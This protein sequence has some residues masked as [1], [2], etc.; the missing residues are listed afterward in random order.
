M[1]VARIAGEIVSTPNWPDDVAFEG[2]RVGVIG[3]GSSGIQAIPV[4][5]ETAGHVTVFQRTPSFTVPARN[6]PLTSEAIASH[7]AR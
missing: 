7:K 1:T 4:I 6:A 3:T 5:A 2:K